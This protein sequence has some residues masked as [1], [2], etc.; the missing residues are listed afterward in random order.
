MADRLAGYFV[1]AVLI[2]SAL[3][4]LV[5][6]QID[7]QRAVWVMLSVL[8]VTCPCALSLASPTAMTAAVAWLRR[9]GLLVTRG[10]V[11]EGLTQVD[12]VIFDKTGTLTVGSPQI[13]QLLTAS[14][15]AVSEE[16]SQ[17]L[18]AICA[19]LEVGS[20][21]PIAK[22]FSAYQ[23]VQH[24]S[25]LRQVT[26]QGVEGVVG[27]TQ[28]RLGKPEF[29]AK[30]LRPPQQ[31][32]QWLVLGENVPSAQDGAWR[33]LLWIQLRDQ[34]RDSAAPLI[35]KLL[36]R[37][38]DVELLSGDGEAE[39]ERVAKELGFTHWRHSQSPDQK[40]SI[41]QMLQQRGDKVL[42]VGDGI[43]DVPV[44]SG[45]YVSVAM[46]GATD[47][48]QTRADSVL[49]GSDL[50]ALDRAFVCADI[51]RK[52]IRQNLSWALCYNLIALPLAALG[53]V[54]PWAAAIGMSASS[55]VVVGNALRISRQ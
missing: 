9:R 54:P 35:E 45:A 8:V 3:V 32:G 42:M 10:H 15:D 22:A 6:W 27:N 29:L 38:L 21:H 2:V 4:G 46:G 19:A 39:V 51:T 53:L 18:L 41:I 55:L 50:M 7:S 23:G 13:A 47:L 24:A 26:A 20:T 28:Y 31:S 43:N 11:L 17:L 30:G 37:G 49:L 1:G 44:L 5:W 16:Q 40:L 25:Q 36:A 52:I 33:P 14:L 34:L 48:A 12:R